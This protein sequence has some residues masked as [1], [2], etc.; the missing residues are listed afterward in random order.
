[1][2]AVR[3]K[4]PVEDSSLKKIVIEEVDVQ[5][6]A[7]STF[8]L[9][10]LINEP[11]E[12]PITSKKVT[13]IDE[14][15]ILDPKKYILSKTD[16]KGFIEYGNEYFVEIAGYTE[17][18]LIGKNHNIIRHPDMPKI[19]FQLLWKR[20]ENRQNIT[21]VVKN[22]AKDGRYYWVV[23]DF[24]IKVDKVTNDI[25]GYFAYR[26]AAPRK[27]ITAIEPLYKK[28]VSIEKESGMDGSGKYLNALLEA[29]GKT[30]DQFINEITGKNSTMMRLLFSAMKKFFR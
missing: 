15:I 25:T 18:E 1:M 24:E 28:L 12:E 11:A 22:M 13:P 7:S 8:S 6:V 29:E 4:P 16:T 14:E 10:K 2:I 23:T 21:A 9:D 30:Y 26:T 5:E 20:I 3:K 27:A 19:V 17:E